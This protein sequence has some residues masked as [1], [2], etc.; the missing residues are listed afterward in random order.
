MLGTSAATQSSLCG[1][2]PKEPSLVS[3]TILLT[4]F[5]SAKI[6]EGKK[7]LKSIAIIFTLFAFR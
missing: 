3:A 1:N 5:I 7:I 4:F 2:K 6:R